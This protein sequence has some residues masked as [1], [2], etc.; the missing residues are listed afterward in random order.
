MNELS[1]FIKDEGEL[2]YLAKPAKTE[3]EGVQIYNAMTNPTGRL[4]DMVNME[5]ELDNVFAEK[6]EMI[7]QNTGELVE[8]IRCVLI[9]PQ[10]ESYQCVSKGVFKAIARMLQLFG[11]PDTWPAPKKIRPKL[12]TAGKNQVLTIEMC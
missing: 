3:E 5:I 7:D 4:K 12:I 8:S 11:T 9:T 2:N 6:L 1:T 10:G